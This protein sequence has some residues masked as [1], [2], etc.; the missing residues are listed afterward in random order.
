MGSGAID[1]LVVA[2]QAGG[3]WAFERLYAT[4]ARSVAGYL[5]TQGAEDPDD[6][7][8]EVFVQVF[9][10]IESFEGNGR[11]FR[12]WVF[13]I[14]HHRLIDDRRRR[15]RR[16]AAEPLVAGED[17]VGGDV[18]HEALAALGD[19]R[20][21]VLLDGL[22][23]DQRDVLTLRVVADLSITETARILGKR[24]TAVK[25]LQ[26]RGLRSLREKMATEAVDPDESREGRETLH[27]DMSPTDELSG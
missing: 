8:N 4:L 22:S 20:V 26:R 21:A 9:R 25:A 7:T 2:A 27:A 16:V 3:G 12:S 17:R 11:A 15:T 10:G 13:S 24:E 6:L 18:E 19:R 1:E 23:R 5:R 14:A